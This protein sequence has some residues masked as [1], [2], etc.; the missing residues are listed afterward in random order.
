MPVAHEVADKGLC[1]VRG[2]I[3]QKDGP[4]YIKTAQ[5]RA[6]GKVHFV[7]AGKVGNQQLVPDNRHAFGR[8]KTRDPM[9]VQNLP[10]G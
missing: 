4:R 7:Q 2:D 5:Q 3:I 1:A 8:I 6:G 10:V 9:R